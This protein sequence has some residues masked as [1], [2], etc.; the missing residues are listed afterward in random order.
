MRLGHAVWR[1]LPAVNCLKSALHNGSAASAE[2]AVPFPDFLHAVGAAGLQQKIQR[3]PWLLVDKTRDT[4]QEN[5]DLGT[6]G[7]LLDL[8]RWLEHT[9][10]GVNVA[11]GLAHI[12]GN[13]YLAPELELAPGVTLTPEQVLV[14]NV[15]GHSEV[16]I[17]AIAAVSQ[18]GEPLLLPSSR[19]SSHILQEVGTFKKLRW[20]RS[21]A[22]VPR[23]SASAVR[24]KKPMATDDGQWDPKSVAKPAGRKWARIHPLLGE[25]LQESGVAGRQPGSC[26]Q[27]ANYLHI[28]VE[29]RTLEELQ[30]S[31]AW[32]AAARSYRP[33]ALA[34]D[35]KAE[36]PYAGCALRTKSGQLFGGSAIGAR[37]GS[38]SPL[39]SALVSL[40]ANGAQ[41]SQ[42]VSAVWTTAL[43]RP[44]SSSDATLLASAAETARLLS[45][46]DQ[47]LLGKVAPEAYFEVLPGRGAREIS[48]KNL[49]GIRSA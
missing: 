5:L 26:F 40:G 46:S 27:H 1:T 44:G 49:A 34:E 15:F 18:G 29:G 2:S 33:A 42:V 22:V 37:T 16:G 43:D 4:L 17:A 30:A 24:A 32:V 35:G 21:D 47:E 39:E 38:V 9:A 45:A 31:F 20:L 10:G 12:S 8:A 23:P 28:D 3:K 7:F 11:V 41:P 36:Q 48:S 14:A 25:V 6:D 13:V 19:R